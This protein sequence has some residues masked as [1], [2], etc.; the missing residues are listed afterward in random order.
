MTI[1]NHETHCLVCNCEIVQK[2]SRVRRFCSSRCK[3]KFHQANSFEAQK[4]RGM[5]RKD[6]LIEMSGGKCCHCGYCK[7]RS[8]LSFHHKNPPDKSFS[9]D[10]R[11]ISNRSWKSCLSE[12]EKC[13]LLCLNCHAEL[14]NPTHTMR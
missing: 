12:F 6:V 13:I 7:N 9:L 1:S 8:A 4:K 3:S 5:E 2:Q 14:H 11:H 10:S